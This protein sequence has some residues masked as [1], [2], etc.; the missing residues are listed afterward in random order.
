MTPKRSTEAGR[1]R[2]G[3]RIEAGL[4][5]S[6]RRELDSPIY[7]QLR[8]AW[9]GTL[10]A[11]P[12]QPYPGPLPVDGGQAAGER[13]LDAG[14]DL[15]ALGRAFISNPDLVERI[16]VGAPLN[17]LRDR[18]M[19]VGGSA[20]YTDYPTLNSSDSGE[21]RNAAGPVTVG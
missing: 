18:H 12:R 21:R 17:P 11:N 4:P 16:R 20:G 9:P 2:N 14:A 6:D 10:I 8:R 1:H 7:R 19:Y 3:R 13:L 15:I 5:A